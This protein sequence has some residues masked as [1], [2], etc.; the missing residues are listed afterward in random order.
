MGCLKT[1]EIKC[2][3]WQCGPIADPR[4]P[5]W[6][7][8]W[9]STSLH[10]FCLNKCPLANVYSQD[11]QEQVHLS[12]LSPVY[13]MAA[14]STWELNLI[15]WHTCIGA[16]P[17]N[18]NLTK[19]NNNDTKTWYTCKRMNKQIHV[20]QTEN[21]PSWNRVL[22]KWFNISCSKVDYNVLMQMGQKSQIKL[23]Y[24]RRSMMHTINHNTIKTNNTIK[25]QRW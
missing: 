21:I 20:E 16:T 18:Y 23:D 12:S 5:A 9:S 1:Q 22:E 7:I 17:P 2:C 14:N 15:Y 11:S 25:T 10:Y 13:Y 24:M 6:C 19:A 3:V 4:C 8:A